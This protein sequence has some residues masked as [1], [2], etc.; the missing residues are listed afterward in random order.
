MT[1]TRSLTTTGSRGAGT[2][3][4]GTGTGTRTGTAACL[5][6]TV[7][8]IA[9]GTTATGTVTGTGTGT[10]TGGTT[11]L[12][13]TAG[14][15]ID[16]RVTRTATTMPIDDMIPDAITGPNEMETR[17]AGGEFSRRECFSL[18]LLVG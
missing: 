13:G 14:T 10:G 16:G 3:T 9:T 12:L 5:P 1:R 8:A 7:A 15:A 11:R 6:A 18:T 17:P 4:A 2:T